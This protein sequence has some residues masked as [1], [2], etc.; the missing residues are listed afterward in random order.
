VTRSSVVVLLLSTLASPLRADLALREPVSLL[1]G[2]TLAEIEIELACPSCTEADEVTALLLWHGQDRPRERSETAAL[3]TL[4]WAAGEFE[5]ALRGAALALE[6]EPADAGW[7]L[8]VP[9]GGRGLPDRVHVLGAGLATDTGVAWPAAR[10][11]ASGTSRMVVRLEAQSDVLDRHSAWDPARTDECDLLVPKR[12]EPPVPLYVGDRPRAWLLPAPGGRGEWRFQFVHPGRTLLERLE[13]SV[14]PSDEGEDW[15]FH[16]PLEPLLAGALADAVAR[17]GG[18][19][20]SPV[21]R[22]GDVGEV[23]LADCPRRVGGP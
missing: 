4:D 13:V 19:G 7:L 11:P 20:V 16:V 6:A 22:V 18:A 3:R 10:W 8:R 17:G 12:L 9:L 21:V 2:R 14:V 5:L 23:A 15:G 1:A